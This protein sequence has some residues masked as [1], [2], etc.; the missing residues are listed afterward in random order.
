MKTVCAYIA[1]NEPKRSG[2]L[3]ERPTLPNRHGI[4]NRAWDKPDR[5]EMAQQLAVDLGRSIT[6]W[7]RKLVGD[8]Q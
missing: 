7:E 5:H 6:Y 8:D 4:F 3:A 1:S 2:I